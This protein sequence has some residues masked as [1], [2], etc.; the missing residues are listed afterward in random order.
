MARSAAPPARRAVVRRKQHKFK[1][2]CAQHNSPRRAA[3]LSESKPPQHTWRAAQE[4]ENSATHEILNGT[5][6]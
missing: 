3:Q 2:C 6:H 1:T 4:S 5:V